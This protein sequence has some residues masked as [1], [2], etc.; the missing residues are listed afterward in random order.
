MAAKTDKSKRCIGKYNIYETL[1][2]GGY[3]W[4]KKGEDT[5]T[6][7]IV[8]LKFMNRATDQW[9]LEQAEQV[10]TEIKSLTQ[11]RH[12]HVMK[13]YAYNLSA[14]YPLNEGGFVKTILLVLEYCPG[15]ELFDILYYADKLE[16]D[17]ARTY[18]KQ[19][20]EGIAAVHKAGIAHRDMKPQNLL[21]D[22]NF[23]LKIT[24]FGLSKIIEKE[25]D[26]IMK[27]TYVGT[28]GYQAPELLKNQKYTNACDIFSMGV[29]LFILLAGYPPFEA[30]H[31]T[32]KW[33]RPLATKDPQK[34]W[35]VHRG[36]KI[37]E[38]A[39][40]LILGMLAYRP[41]SRWSIKK[42][43]EHK[44]YS[45]GTVKKED[46]K[47]KVLKRFLQARE[48]RKKD[49]KKTKDLV[50][51]NHKPM[52]KDKRRNIFKD[53]ECDEALVQKVAPS[54]EKGK[55]GKHMN[56]KASL[57]SFYASHNAFKTLVAL[58]KVLK[59][60]NSIDCQHDTKNAVFELNCKCTAQV[61]GGD[62]AKKVD[63]EFRINVF[64]N[65]DKKSL[66]HNLVH[67]QPTHVPDT[68]L[69]Q[70]IYRDMI[71][72]INK[73]D[74]FAEEGDPVPV[75]DHNSEAD[76]ASEEEDSKEQEKDVAEV[77]K[78]PEPVERG[79]FG[80]DDDDQKED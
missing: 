59:N 12:E 80:N 30:A 42:I 56:I 40:E 55:F 77:E 53:L 32:D 22:T 46:L 23:S 47:E 29:I 45:G 62:D 28:R 70:R 72:T 13:L 3:S 5:E 26:R 38:S 66:H 60:D 58:A 51:S 71:T 57:R 15:G 61:G 39:K 52:E 24:D 18:F 21:L 10:R 76:E 50:D 68:F 2:K 19:M 25:D 65:T 4:V 74:I 67:I 14:K 8:A 54:L 64:R 1:G 48:N 79:E 73:Y 27:T 69:W 63:F 11:I 31:K 33:Y 43:M 16:E 44:W 49:A 7:A 35:H 75:V 34:F 78:K 20:I 41:N 6:G 37:D 17:L 36:A 9:A